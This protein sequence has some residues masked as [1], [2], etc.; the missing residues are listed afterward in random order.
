MMSLEEVKAKCQR[1]VRDGRSKKEIIELLHDSGL[2][3]TESMKIIMDLYK[4]SLGE[5][6]M[7]V[8]SHPAWKNVV[9]AASPLHKDLIR[10]IE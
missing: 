10:K 7:I 9:H 3:I 6:K 2:T 5:A 1:E 8:V 4:I